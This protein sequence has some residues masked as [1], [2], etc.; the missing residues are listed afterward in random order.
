M[1][2]RPH[3][4]CLMVTRQRSD[5]ARRSIDAFARQDYPNRDLV[6]VADGGTETHDIRDF[7]LSLDRRDISVIELPL[8][9]RPLGALRN[10]AVKS[11][12]G[13]Y[14]CQWDDD[15]LYHPSRL[16]R[17]VEHAQAFGR[18]ACVLRDQLQWICADRTLYWC[19]WGRP[20]Q[21]PTWP[22]ATPNS[23]LCRRTQMPTYREVGPLSTRS[24]DLAVMLELLKR[25]DLAILSGFGTSYIYTSHG[26]NTWDAA[27]HLGIPRVT[28]LSASEIEQRHDLLITDLSAYRFTDD[29]LLRAHDGTVVYE[30]SAAGVATSAR[31]ERAN[32]S[33]SGTDCGSM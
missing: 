11:A 5:M 3:V 14:V 1:A 19:D 16:S 31:T 9:S 21:R 13:D 10:L 17:Q 7:V 8:G 12:T 30:V 32:T 25:S 2:S 24:E 15:D 20:R 27:H 18:A 22:P 28:G 33:A 23:L 6:I 29:L 26:A 4:T